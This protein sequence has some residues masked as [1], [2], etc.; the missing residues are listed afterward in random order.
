MK[1]GAHIYLW[2][3]RWADREV[4]LCGRAK[5]LGLDT[6]ELSVGLDVPFDAAL[7][8]RAAADAGI[9]LVLGPGGA[10]PEHADLAADEPAHRQ[11]AYA[12]FASA[13]THL[14]HTDQL[15]ARSLSIPLWSQMDDATAL[16][17]CAAIQRIYESAV[18]VAAQW[19]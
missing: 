3:E 14:P 9:S 17:I 4:G 8:R 10:W 12:H 2:I 11:T 5:A 18:T 13:H 6:L 7:T 1:L 15:A 16:T 19:A